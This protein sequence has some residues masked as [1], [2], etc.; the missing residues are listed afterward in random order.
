MF[1]IVTVPSST[2]PQPAAP[3]VRKIIHCDC[4]CFYASVEMRDDP[5]L[6]GRPLAVGGRPD[7]RGVIATCNY[8]AR[9][10]GIH[11]AMSSALAM[12][13]CPDLLILPS[14]MDK[15][16][17]AS[18]QIMAIYRDYTADVEPLSLDEAYLD[19]THAS[20][21]KGSA[22]LIAREIRERVRRTVGVTVSAGVAPSKFIAKIASDWNKPDGLFVVRPH[23]VDAFVA[24]LPV[25]KIHGVG[26][27]TA[28]KLERLG[29]T[30]C[31]QLRAW[32]LV[33]LH[34]HFGA[35]GRRLYELARG[36]DERPVRADQERKSVSVETTYVTD[37]KTL[38]AC[39]DELR[40]LARQLDE[41]IAR[42]GV[43]HA[44]RK[45]FVKIRFANFQ[46]TTVEC[47]RD[48]TDLPTLLAMLE[49]GL[50]RRREPV[51]LLGVGVRLEEE[52]AGSGGQFALFD[53]ELDD[54]VRALP[55]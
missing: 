33:E 54:D 10:F 32:P 48:A 36:I 27:V 20:H 15:Y 41:R 28:A 7:Q 17:A 30:T 12:R 2:L 1:I 47:V 6:R 35:F 5:S 19:V 8:D 53:T 45:L 29:L 46:R 14:A 24:A 26:K 21:H 49:K 52:N 3:F 11:S 55:D 16:R 39:G 18:K 50:A 51:R 4:D 23:E 40:D 9:R 22:T 42:A 43:A 44:V 37:L 38:E 25:R 34:R 31:A 13:K